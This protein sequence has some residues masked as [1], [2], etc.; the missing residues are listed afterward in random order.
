MEKIIE[1]QTFSQERSL[2]NLKDTTIKNCKIEGEEDGESSLKECRNIQVIDTELKL[3]YP[4]WHDNQFV[5]KDSHMYDTCRAALWYCENGSILNSKLHGIKALRECKNVSLNNCDI[6]SEEF[7]WKCENIIMINS[8]LNSMYV[9]F[10]SNDV[11]LRYVQFKGK[12]SFQYVKNLIIE[13]CQLDTKDAFWHSK[14][15]VIKNSVVKGE[16][17]GWYSEDLTLINCTIT[18]TQPLCYCKH[19]TLINCTMEGCD[20]AFE[21]CTN[22][23]AEVRGN[24]KSIKNPLSGSIKVDSV[25]EV[26]FDNTVY[27]GQAE[28]IINS[29]VLNHN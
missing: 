9:F 7:G 6:I 8:S 5:M 27:E 12:Y 18:G 11:T 23:A 20:L 22:I 29:E 2:Y 16:Y 25:D 14:N 10:E 24:I 21:N 28:I 15:V 4:M 3:R 13:N 17:L 26:I 19:L 1:N